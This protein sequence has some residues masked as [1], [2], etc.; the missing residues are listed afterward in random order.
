MIVLCASFGS[1]APEARRD[2]RG[3][4]GRAARRRA[5]LRLCARLHQPPPS[6]ASWPGAGKPFPA[7][8]R[9]SAASPAAPWPFSPRSFCAAANTT[10]CARR[11]SRAPTPSRA[12]SWAARLLDAPEDV[13]ALARAVAQAYPAQPG[14]SLLLLG[15]GTDGPAAAVYPALQAALRALSR[16]DAFVA[17]VAG[18]AAPEDLLPALRRAPAVRLA[19]LLLVA[20]EHARKDM[21]GD[22]P[23][24]WKSRLAAAGLSVRCTAAGARLPPRR[25]GALTRSACARC[26]RR[27]MAFEHYVRSGQSSC[28]AATPRGRA[29]RWRRR[30]RRPSC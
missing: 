10:R 15:H 28:A 17:T 13:P 26:W 16:E 23:A 3:R 5:G 21:A 25:A 22:G 8:P 7:C 19:P 4:R 30:A 2:N 1:S 27:T 14:E 9:R 6:A 29:R 12:C 20:G 24:S 11:R 18:G